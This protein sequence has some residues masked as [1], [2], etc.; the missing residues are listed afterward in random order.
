MVRRAEEAHILAVGV[1]ALGVELA[2]GQRE[3]CERRSGAVDVSGGAG[4]RRRGGLCQGRGQAEAVRLLLAIN[5]DGSRVEEADGCV[6]GGLCRGLANLRMGKGTK[7]PHLTCPVEG[8][9]I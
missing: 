6:E 5:E 3:S 7:R 4:G 9:G 8:T 2:G 1:G